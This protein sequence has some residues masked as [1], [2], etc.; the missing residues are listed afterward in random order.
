QNGIFSEYFD[1]SSQKVTRYQS[2][3]SFFRLLKRKSF[4]NIYFFERSKGSTI[5]ESYYVMRS[6]A[7]DKVIVDRYILKAG[8]N[9]YHFHY[10][11]PTNL[12]YLHHFPDGKKVICSFWGS[13]LM[14]ETGVDNV[15]YVSKALEKADCITVQNAE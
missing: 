2:V 15:F 3:K 7:Y 10:C 9:F 1:F 5:R 13:D 6:Y 8:Y 4:W 12:K 14:R 11:N